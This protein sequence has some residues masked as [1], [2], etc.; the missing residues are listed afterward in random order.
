MPAA[1]FPKRVNPVLGHGRRRQGAAPG[2]QRKSVARRGSGPPPGGGGREPRS[3]TLRALGL[4][5]ARPA[6]PRPDPLRR[7]VREPAPGP[8]QGGVTRGPQARCRVPRHVMAGLGRLRQRRSRRQIPGA[9]HRLCGRLL[10]LRPDGADHG[11]CDRPHLRLPPQPGRNRRPRRRRPVQGV[12]CAGLHRRAGAGRGGGR[13]GA[14]RDRLR[15][16]GLRR[17]GG[18]R[19]QRLGR[20]TRPV[21][22]AS[23]RPCSPKW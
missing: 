21:A 7:R 10:R 1:D 19:H 3:G 17:V 22:T 6:R 11:L 20:P 23:P 13:R 5:G 15:Q 12:G 2:L 18:L 8:R 16:G 14:L 4:V 9:R